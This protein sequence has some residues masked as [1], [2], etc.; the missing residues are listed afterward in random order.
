MKIPLKNKIFMWF[1]KGGGV[2]LT[3]DNLVRRIWNGSKVC[4]LCNK[5]ET[6]KHLFFDCHYARFLWRAVHWV[7]GITPP[8]S[9]SHLFGD[10]QN[11]A[12]ANTICLF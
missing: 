1:L 7:F 6:I 3:K 10:G 5:L 11:W 8:T 12:A 2:I 4:C 9:V